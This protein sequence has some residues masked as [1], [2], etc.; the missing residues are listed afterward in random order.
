MRFS[1]AMIIPLAALA[2]AAVLPRSELGS[3]AVSISKSAYANGYQSMTA[4][5]VY[6]SDAYPES[7]SSTCNYVYNP[8]AAADSKETN[9]CSEGFEYSFDGTS[10]LRFSL[11]DRQKFREESGLT[12]LKLFL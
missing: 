5:A 7:I 12:S 9:V 11:I 3:W 8:S 4:T 6:T 1:T 2:S 10:K